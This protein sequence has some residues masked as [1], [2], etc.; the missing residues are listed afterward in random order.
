MFGEFG[1]FFQGKMFGL[2]CDDTLFIKVTMAGAEFAGRINKAA[3]YPGA[4]EAFKISALKMNNAEWIQKLV[5]ITSK[6][7]PLPK[8]KKSS[9]K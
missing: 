6:E 4:K 7:L 1:L 2:I 5:K 9:K 3:P 8:V